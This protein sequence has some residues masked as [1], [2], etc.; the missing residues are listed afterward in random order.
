MNKRKALV[1]IIVGLFVGSLTFYTT[2][3]LA[4]SHIVDN[5][6]VLVEKNLAVE[7]KAKAI[8]LHGALEIVHVFAKKW[9]DDAALISL[10]SADVDD[11]YAMGID[12]IEYH[13]LGQNGRRRTWQAVLTSPSL[14]K[15]LFLQI[16]D[17]VVVEALEDGIHDIRIPTLTWEPVIDSPE[18]LRQAKEMKPN[19]ST[20]VGR[21]K[22]YHFVFQTDNN[23]NPILTIVGSHQAGSAQLPVAI[24]FDQETGQFTE[25]KHYVDYG[26]VSQWEDF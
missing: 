6:N 24:A 8:T 5:Y 7:P 19:F 9:S 2:S 13:Q 25:S 12:R 26:G 1:A 20:S 17:G 18:I 14:N 23:G 10:A 21:G 15:Q 16:T 4:E 3:S 11:P 22:G